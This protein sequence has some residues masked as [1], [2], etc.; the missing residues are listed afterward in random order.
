MLWNIFQNDLSYN[1]ESELNMYADG[2]QFYE[3]GINLE[4]VRLKLKESAILASDWYRENLLEGNFGKYRIM[5][6]GRKGES[7]EV[8]TENGIKIESSD[9][10][11]LFGVGYTITLW[12]PCLDGLIQT[13]GNDARVKK[14]ERNTSRRRV[15]FRA[16]LN[17]SNIPK[18]LDQAIQTRKP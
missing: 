13:R 12:F 3:S 6:F 8:E 2:H 4:S 7:I 9:C 10:I 11:R 5:T 16:F 18:C 15:I 17:S 1:I 14:S